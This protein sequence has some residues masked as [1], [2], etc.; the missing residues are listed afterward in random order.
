MRSLLR[1]SATPVWAMLV[2]GTAASCWLGPA[3]GSQSGRTLATTTVLTIAFVKVWLVGREFMELRRA[4]AVLRLLFDGWIVLV[5][6]SLT[7]IYL[8]A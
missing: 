4:P 5:Y 1:T 7:G 6:G 2:L 8:A 3:Y